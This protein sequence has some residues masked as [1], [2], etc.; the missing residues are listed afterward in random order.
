MQTPSGSARPSSPTQQKIKFVCKWGG[1]F[2]EPNG[3]IVYER[4]ET[5]L[6]TVPRSINYPQLIFKLKELSGYDGLFDMRFAP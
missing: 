4:G 6:C 5:R 3:G 2:S 1:T